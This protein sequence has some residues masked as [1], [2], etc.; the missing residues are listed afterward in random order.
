MPNDWASPQTMSAP[1]LPGASRIPRESLGHGDDQQ[2]LG[3]VDG[4][5]AGGQ[6][7]DHAEEVG[8][9]DD[10][11]ADVRTRFRPELL[12]IEAAVPAESDFLHGQ[13]EVPGQRSDCLPVLGMEGAGDENPAPTGQAPGHEGGFGR[14]RGAV[15]KGSVGDVHPGQ[16][17]DQVWY[18]KMTWRVPWLTSG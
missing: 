14:G 8:G 12:R 10:Q 7:L 9:L 2:A 15:I 17:A 16:T 3:L 13:S 4:G 6:I 5:R 11:A 1:S 18:S